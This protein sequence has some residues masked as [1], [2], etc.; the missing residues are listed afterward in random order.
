[1][2]SKAV[3]SIKAGWAQI[4]ITPPLG[5]PMGGRGA[6]FTDGASIRDPLYAQACALQDSTGRRT[7]W[8]SIDLIGL[9]SQIGLPLRVDV[10]AYTGIP[11]EAVILNYAHTH[12]GPMTNFDKYPILRPKPE[13]LR[14]YERDLR[15]RILRVAC[16]AV[17]RLRPASATL[18]QGAS[19]VGINRRDRNAAGE[20]AMAPNPAG[21]YNPELWVVDVVA[22][23]GGRCVVFSYGCH[24]VIAYG[25]AYDAISADYPGAARRQI[26]EALGGGVHCQFVQGLAGDVR[27]R[28]LA[29]LEQGRFRK[30]TP[31]DLEQAGRELAG[32]V[33][34]ALA[35]A[36]EP[37]ELELRAAGGWFQAVR[38]VDALPPLA[39]W[40]AM[41]ERE[42]ELYRNVGRYWA[43]FFEAG[44]PA[45]R[46][47]PWEVGLLQLTRE[48]RIAWLAGEVV[49]E[50][51][52]HLRRWLDDEDLIV[53]GYCQD[54]PGYL[55]TD[56]LLPEG[57][58]E[59][60]QSNL[61]CQT[62][63]APL[64]AGVNEAVRARVLGLAKQVIS[65]EGE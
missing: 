18:Y 47:T 6:R 21:A 13:G 49:A 40:Q 4:D 31:A 20:M 44:W 25:F 24:A 35:G 16:D 61:N 53:W 46:A 62:G 39:H 2:R 64:A 30:A 19:D 60:A 8:I 22:D 50:W 1:M 28:V 23:D 33:V 3:D 48:R 51:G 37:L 59:V 5:L 38:D 15:T 12:S 45:V 57:G 34:G 56:E 36:G 17:E 52:P 63:P 42:E 41:A 7:L 54:L 26:E 58:Y 10:A 43:A 27:P 14:A 55:P 32:A 65:D 9:A 29:D 11:R